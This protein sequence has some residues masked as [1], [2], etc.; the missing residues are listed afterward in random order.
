MVDQIAAKRRGGGLGSWDCGV[1]RVPSVIM[2][3]KQNIRPL[4]SSDG[5]TKQLCP[6]CQRILYNRALTHCGFCGA[7]IPEQLRFNAEEIAALEKL[8]ADLEQDRVERERA[9]SE[10][11]WRKKQEESGFGLGGLM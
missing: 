2:S 7:K 5:A 9:A 10:Q 8:K 1:R 6:A 4:R 11:G 3:Q